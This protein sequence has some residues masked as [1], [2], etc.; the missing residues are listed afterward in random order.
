M[1]VY[2]G[3]RRA[4]D[5]IASGSATG[6]ENIIAAGESPNGDFAGPNRPDKETGGN[7]ST[8]ALALL[9]TENQ[10]ANHANLSSGDYP[11]IPGSTSGTSGWTS[12]TTKTS[13]FP[14]NV[15]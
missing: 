4:Y 2:K 5:N 15:G 8:S 6:R 11:E 13:A 9:R 3:K 7:T 12:G 10:V 1:F 14:E